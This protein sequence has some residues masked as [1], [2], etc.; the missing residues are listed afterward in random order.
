MDKSMK[1]S[2][3]VFIVG[4]SI[5]LL[6]TNIDLIH[7]WI[8]DNNDRKCEV[9]RKKAKEPGF[10]LCE[11]CNELYCRPKNTSNT[12]SY[13]STNYSNSKNFTDTSYLSKESNYSNNS[14]YTNGKKITSTYKK[15]ERDLEYDPIDYDDPDEY[16]D[17]AWEIDFD[18]YD[19][20]YDYWEDY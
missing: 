16:S 4:L 13:T 8:Q 3:I 9:C 12:C 6:G 5:F 11:E 10:Y 19:D 15:D 7:K 18:D 20:A 1:Q 17:D 2:I 14:S